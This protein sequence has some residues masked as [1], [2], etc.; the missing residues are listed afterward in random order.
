MPKAKKSPVIKALQALP[1]DL[2]TKVVVDRQDQYGHP[3]EVYQHVSQLWHAAFGWDVTVEQV[4]MALLLVK[5]G[6]EVTNPGVV[7]DNLTDIAGYANVLSMV[8]RG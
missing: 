8:R 2:A 6:R 1:S 4:A 7:D 5:V 3:A